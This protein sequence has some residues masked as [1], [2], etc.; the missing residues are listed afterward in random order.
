MRESLIS[1]AS[2]L[3]LVRL[4]TRSPH[5]SDEGALDFS[6]P[7]AGWKKETRLACFLTCRQLA[8]KAKANRRSNTFLSFLFPAFC[9][10]IAVSTVSRKLRE[11]RGS[12]I[13]RGKGSR[14]SAGGLKEAALGIPSMDRQ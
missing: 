6:V 4:A 7:G 2:A 11:P 14:I 8:G 3:G 10:E 1:R 9:H 13:L 5:G 12:E